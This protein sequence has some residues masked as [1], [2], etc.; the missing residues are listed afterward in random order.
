MHILILEICGKLSR[1]TNT[2]IMNFMMHKMT[3]SRTH[4]NL[5]VTD[6]GGSVSSGS[7]SDKLIMVIG[8]TVGIVVLLLGLTICFVW[9]RN[10]LQR[11]W[12]GKTE[13]KGTE[14]SAIAKMSVK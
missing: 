4:I 5:F 9:K 1:M 3:V 13:Q 7:G 12:K 14:I 2:K 6:D 10:E 11:I 8:I